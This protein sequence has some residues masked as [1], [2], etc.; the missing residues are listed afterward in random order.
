MANTYTAIPDG[1]DVWGR[2]RMVTREYNIS[3]N[4]AANGYLIAASDFGLKFFKGI[5]VA[6]V[7]TTAGSGYSVF[8]VLAAGQE[9]LT[10]LLVLATANVEVTPGSITPFTVRLLAYGG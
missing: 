5:V 9:P 6:G 10:A 3:A 2:S 4:Y 8:P 1:N 7:T